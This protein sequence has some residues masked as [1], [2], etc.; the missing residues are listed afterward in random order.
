[1]IK[2]SNQ[3]ARQYFR[4]GKLALEPQKANKFNAV[5]TEYNGDKY[6]SKREARHAYELDCLIKAGEVKKWDRQFKIEINVK[7][8]HI[9]N[10]FIDFKVWMSDGSI[11][12][13]EVKGKETQLWKV[14]WKLVK[15][16][17]P[18]WNFVL[19]K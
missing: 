15:S 18:D 10:Y 13:H 2:L 16:I 3:E 7:G 4:T 12:Y 5:K 1:M 6:D 8:K 11:E 14:K 9:C 19:I 17:Y